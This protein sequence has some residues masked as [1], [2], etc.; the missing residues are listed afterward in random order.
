MYI[1]ELTKAWNILNYLHSVVMNTI[2]YTTTIRTL[3]RF[4]FQFTMNMDLFFIAFNIIYY[5]ALQSC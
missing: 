5:Y 1:Y 4:S 3:M 2:C